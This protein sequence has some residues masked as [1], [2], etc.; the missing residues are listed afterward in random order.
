M[1]NKG[2]KSKSQKENVVVREVEPKIKE[3]KTEPVEEQE[4]D[5]ELEGLSE[6]EIEKI[7]IERE[8]QRQL[9]L[10]AER[11]ARGLSLSDLT[12]HSGMVAP[13]RIVGLEESVS[14]VS[15]DNGEEEDLGDIYSAGGSDVYGA[16]SDLYGGAQD[17]YG[18]GG[19]DAYE[20]G[21]DNGEEGGS[22]ERRVGET[23][24]P[25]NTFSENRRPKA[26]VPRQ[27]YQVRGKKKPNRY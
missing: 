6:E 22:G 17:A 16:G 2:E 26:S 25:S 21:G 11:Q 20:V 23:Q 10:E 7:L 27:D 14:D 9:M 24:S 13:D 12:L 19:S 1:V 8:E 3:I 5:E 18:A 15:L 4:E